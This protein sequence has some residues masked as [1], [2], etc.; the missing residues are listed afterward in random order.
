MPVTWPTIFRALVVLLMAAHVFTQY[1]LARSM[2]TTAGFGVWATVKGA[3]FGLVMMIPLIWAVALPDLPEILRRA[4]HQRRWEKGRCPACG[5]SVRKG[6][7]PA[8]PE[9][10]APIAEPGPYLFTWSTIRRFVRLAL[11]AWLIGWVMAEGW[12]LA[13]NAGGL[14]SAA[15]M[16]PE[17]DRPK[18]LSLSLKA[19][20][21]TVLVRG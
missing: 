16:S 19:P 18:S 3:A 11:L 2:D 15:M 10:G 7:G 8:C 5:Y 9:C 20:N 12:R 4:R 13:Q 21:R 17:G 1:S 14:P 6:G